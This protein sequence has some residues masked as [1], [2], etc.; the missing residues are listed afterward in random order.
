M[1]QITIDIKP[2]TAQHIHAMLPAHP[3][4]TFP[5]AF[6]TIKLC[7]LQRHV[8]AVKFLL[9]L[10]LNERD[11]KPGGIDANNERFLRLNFIA[12]LNG[13]F[14]YQTGNFRGEHD[15]LNLYQSPIEEL[16]V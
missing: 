11:I 7:F 12:H 13:H 5:Q 8:D 16:F 1:T 3:G 10:R 6:Q 2:E 9:P 14:V 4:L 15:F